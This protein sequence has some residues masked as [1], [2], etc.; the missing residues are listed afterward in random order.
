MTA[1]A[2]ERMSSHEKWSYMTFPLAVGNK[3]WKH[4]IA[5]IDLSTGKVEPGHAESDLLV[6]GVFAETVD[7]TSAEAL[8]NVNF[9]EEITVE[10]FENSTTGAI[11]ATD[12]GN[13]CYVEDDQTVSITPTGS[14][15][16]RIWK[17]SSTQGV[18]VQRLPN[19][20]RSARLLTETVL[21]AF[22]S[23]NINVPSDPASGAIYDIPATGAASTVT[24]PA[25]ASE[26]TELTFV[27]DGTKNGH[28]VQYR[29]ITGTVVLTTALV[30]SKR[31]TVKAIFLNGIW[32]AIAYTAP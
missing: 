5:V 8:V 1:L 17:Y 22:S 24:L 4:G 15:A 19:I 16:G 11:A 13:F 14:I 23:N 21:S 25:A 20:P 6:I 30:A 29:D 26:G 2:Q 9:R 28:T 27:A 32:T 10:W 18:A 31:H 7:A 12:V 3:A